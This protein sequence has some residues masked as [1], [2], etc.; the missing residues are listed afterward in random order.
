MMLHRASVSDSGGKKVV[1][2][3]QLG[4]AFLCLKEGMDFPLQPRGTHGEKA[5]YTLR[6]QDGGINRKV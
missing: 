4:S 6:P 1:W 3:R 2:G 5:G